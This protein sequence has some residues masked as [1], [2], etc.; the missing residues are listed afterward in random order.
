M[1]KIRGKTVIWSDQHF[2][3]KGNSPSRQKICVDVVRKL[4]EFVK[5]EN[6]TTIISAGDWFHSRSQ[7][8]VSTMN[9][10]YRCLKTLAGKCRCIMLLGNHDLYNK[11]T[12][13]VSS[14]NMFQDISNVEIVSRPVQVDLNGKSCLLAPWLSDLSVFQP[15]TFDFLI[16]HFDISAKYLMNSYIEDNRN[17]A[18]ADGLVLGAIDGLHERESSRFLGNFVDL[19]VKGGAVFAGHIHKHDEQT[20]KGRKFMFIGSPYQQTL[21]DV[22]NPCGF[23]LMDEDGGYSF[24]EI[25]GVPRHLI[26]KISDIIAADV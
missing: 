1:Q 9:I 6:V 17:K 4:A 26:L 23:Y 7:V 11:N 20:V 19:A 5:A 21:A 13:D 10:A 3:I 18:S 14:V 24:R 25:T 15:G 22:G 12:V 2:G 8:D 16:G